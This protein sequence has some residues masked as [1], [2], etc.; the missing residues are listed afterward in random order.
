MDY[1]KNDIQNSIIVRNY[2]LFVFD[3]NYAMSKSKGLKE[4]WMPNLSGIYIVT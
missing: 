2:A 3:N 1:S 4:L